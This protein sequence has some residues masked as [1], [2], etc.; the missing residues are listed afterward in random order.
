MVLRFNIGIKYLIIIEVSH[1]CYANVIGKRASVN[2]VL[3]KP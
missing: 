3:T 2:S 1:A